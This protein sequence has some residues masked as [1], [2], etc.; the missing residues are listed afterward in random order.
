[1]QGPERPPAAGMW[2]QKCQRH[3]DSHPPEGEGEGEGEEGE[4]AG[5]RV[6]PGLK[7]CPRQ[8]PFKP[9]GHFISTVIIF[10]SQLSLACKSDFCRC[11]IRT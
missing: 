2:D 7:H 4:E 5:G 6:E 10:C 1:M 8:R 9:G 3:L 11:F